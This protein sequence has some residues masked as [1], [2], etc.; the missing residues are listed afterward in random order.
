V[1]AGILFSD[2]ITSG[3]TG[4]MRDRLRSSKFV[5][6]GRE[7]GDALSKQAD[8]IFSYIYSIKEMP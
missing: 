1:V 3:E 7:K 5:I 8:V 6:L 2:S 4:G